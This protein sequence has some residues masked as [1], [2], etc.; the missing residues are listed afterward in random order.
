MKTLEDYG[1]YSK[2]VEGD[3]ITY[4]Q[5]GNLKPQVV[6]I[7]LINKVIWLG[8]DIGFGDTSYRVLDEYIGELPKGFSYACKCAMSKL[9]EES[10]G[11]LAI[12]KVR[13]DAIHFKCY[14][15]YFFIRIGEEGGEYSQR[16]YVKG[17]YKGSVRGIHFEGPIFWKRGYCEYLK[18]FRLG[19]DTYSSI[20]KVSFLGVLNKIG[21]LEEIRKVVRV[22]NAF[23]YL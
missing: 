15:K 10:N 8:D 1:Y 18:G 17:K 13:R 3:Y 22:W 16:L 12:T 11:N 6:S 19:K 4:F 23:R 7:D 2:T 20:D 14:G 5:K 9:L 21:M